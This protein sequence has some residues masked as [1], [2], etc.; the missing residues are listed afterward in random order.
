MIEKWGKT[1]RT[2]P[3]YNPHFTLDRQVFY[4]LTI[5]GVD[6]TRYPPLASSRKK[7]RPLWDAPTFTVEPKKVSPATEKPAT[8]KTQ[9]KTR[10]KKPA[11]ATS[12]E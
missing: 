5:P 10:T 2:D 8:R 3:F 11:A 6:E 9:T 7:I 4:D 1:L 12:A